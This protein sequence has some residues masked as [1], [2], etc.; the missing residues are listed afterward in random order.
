MSQPQKTNQSA[1]IQ[2]AIH[3][4]RRFKKAPG[5]MAGRETG[6]DFSAEIALAMVPEEVGLSGGTLEAV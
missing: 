4:K 1:T 3:E 2:S 6:L 5:L